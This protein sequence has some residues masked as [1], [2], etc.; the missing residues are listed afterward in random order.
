MRRSCAWIWGLLDERGQ[1]IIVYQ[2]KKKRTNNRSK[3]GYGALR[4]FQTNKFCRCIKHHLLCFSLYAW[5]NKLTWV[6]CCDLCFSL[7]RLVNRDNHIHFLKNHQTSLSCLWFFQA[8]KTHYL[9][10]K[11]SVGNLT[12][13]HGILENE[14]HHCTC[15]L[16]TR[17]EV[18]LYQ[19]GSH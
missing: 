12:I 5:L 4:K 3:V 8:S 14:R 16:L 1:I 13:A 9:R 17:S 19:H 10:Y 6:P 18:F 11:S 15:V 7:I 2:K